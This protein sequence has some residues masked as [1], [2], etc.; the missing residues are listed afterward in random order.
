MKIII[1]YP[2]I[3]TK[4]KGTTPLL[5]QNRQYQEFH[6]E[7]YLFPVVLG[8]AATWLKN[9][10]NDVIWLDAIAEN[11]SKDKFLE[12]IEEE[13]PD[14]FLFETKCPVIK[15]HWKMVDEVK[16]KF[17]DLKIAICGDHVSYLPKETMEKSKVDFVITS[18]FYDFAIVELVDALREEKKI[19]EGIWHSHN[20]KMVENGTYKINK[21]LDDA[22]IIDR[23]LTKNHL[24]QKEYNLKGRPYA[25]IMS[26]RDCY[27]G[28]CKFCVW[29]F[30]LYPKGSF[31]FRSP[32]NVFEEVKYLVDEVGIK[33][34]FDDA[35]TITIGNWLKEFCKLMIDSGYNKKVIYSCNMRFGAIGLEE[36]KLMKEAGFRLLKFGLESANQKTLDRIDKGIKVS[37]IEEGCKMAKKAK[38]E[39]HL[40]MM[41][42]YFFEA[43][44]D[45]LNTLNLAK[46]LMLNGYADILQSTVVVPYPGTPL[47]EE[48]VKE[49]ML[50]V[51]KY[52]YES[53]DMT[54]PILKTHGMTSEE[55]TKICNSIYSKIFLHPRY[56]ARHLTKIRSLN[57]VLYTLNGLK[58]VIGHIKDFGK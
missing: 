42:G 28:K 54:K 16:A 32:Q 52:D 37:D 9:N 34:I 26:A 38:L 31:R 27:W 25:Y 10:G 43:K 58:A 45:A 41:V 23:T 48:A 21:K 47:Y 2:P 20:G 1:G 36:Y 53:F 3:E 5:S 35:G 8:T 12:M 19:P 14:L 55:V 56:I 51:D 30:T 33:E 57:D 17:K 22:P 40:T 24:Y 13:K 18:G 29:N 15:Q 7:T 46:R 50:L 39:V 49:N 44:E 6:N 4:K 11:I